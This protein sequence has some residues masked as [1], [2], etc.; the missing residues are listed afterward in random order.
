MGR[1]AAVSPAERYGA[2]IAALATVLASLGVAGRTGITVD[3]LAWLGTGLVA[4]AVLGRATWQAVRAAPT[5]PA[6]VE[7][8]VAGAA[9][10][11]ASDEIGRALDVLE[12]AGASLPRARARAVVDSI[13]QAVA[14]SN[15]V[16]ERHLRPP[17][18]P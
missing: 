9:E 6:A 5:V 1:L 11:L 2:V 18:A 4:L 8:G 14:A 15:P 12:R 17:E 7:A 3:D 16:V 13:Q 10:A